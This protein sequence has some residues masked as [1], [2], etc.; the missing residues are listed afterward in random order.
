MQVMYTAQATAR[1]G[2]RNGQSATDDGKI[3]LKMTTPKE[4]GGSGEGANPEQ[5]FAVGYAACYLGALRAAA[6]KEKV[7]LPEDT[8]ITAR[9]G[10]GKRDDGQGFG[11]EVSLD[12]SLP[13]MDRAQAEALMEKAHVICPYSHSI[14]GNVAVKTRAV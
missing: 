7:Q 10:L 14:R 5:L 12:G 2:G 8:T 4:M 6:A 11:L 9:V 1:G 3:D 13:G